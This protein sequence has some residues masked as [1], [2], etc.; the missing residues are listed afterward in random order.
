MVD[1]AAPEELDSAPRLSD[2]GAAASQEK[3]DVRAGTGN[4]Y[5][6]LTALQRVAGSP[7]L[8]VDTSAADGPVRIVM[9]S[10]AGE[11]R[12]VLA[13]SSL[14]KG[15]QTSEPFMSIVPQHL[16]AVEGA[17]HA[18]LRKVAA[19]VLNDQVRGRLSGIAL[20]HARALVG[21]LRGR[22]EGR[23]VVVCDLDRLVR[24][25]ALDT[26]SEGI[27]GTPWGAI[28]DYSGSNT[29][30]HALAQLMY[31]LHA[32]VTDLTDRR[33][34]EPGARGGSED[35]AA[36][37]RRVLVPFVRAEI[38][39]AR[40][41]AGAAQSML[42]EWIAQEPSLSD[43]ELENLCLTFLTMGHENVS[44]G[45]AWTLVQ[46][47][48]NPAAQDSV[49]AQVARSAFWRKECAG[50]LNGE[51]GVFEALA[52]LT[53]VEQAFLESARLYPSVPVISRM[54]TTDTV[55]AGYRIPAGTEVVFNLYGLNRDTEAWG[56]D[57]AQFACPRS[58]PI[59]VDDPSYW[60]FGAGARPCVGRPL[61]GAESKAV[62]ATLLMAFSLTS[63]SDQKVQANNLV[64]L[65]PGQH[66]I[67]LTPLTTS[68]RL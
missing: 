63:A 28:V 10:D 38:S 17:V 8:V 50:E 11:A 39:S 22:S 42:C 35:E 25:V 36:T 58:K 46:L 6:A 3:R 34:R 4:P 66:A 31:V 23:A 2:G 61:S 7:A 56:E 60:S 27:F 55:V 40:A 47:A 5:E 20:R 49:R 16:I 59:Q 32:R 65:R 37:W 43:A 15:P 51:A 53:L 14:L 44:S 33:W 9:V 57:A 19:S 12:R 30:A 62:V 29:K 64:S 1:S 68:S 18:R 48:E 41:G 21:Q 67:R 26:I 24:A 52:E 13:D 54:A 45:I